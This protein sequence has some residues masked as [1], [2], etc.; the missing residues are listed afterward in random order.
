MQVIEAKQGC[1]YFICHLFRPGGL[2]FA[3]ELEHRFY[4]PDE[5]INEVFQIF[6]V[7]YGAGPHYAIEIPASKQAYQQAETLAEE[8][9]LKLVPG[10]PFNG[11]DEFPIR[12]AADK[13]F[14][15][16]TAVHDAMENF[17]EEITALKKKYFDSLHKKRDE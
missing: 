14:V 11:Q 12:C 10:K 1:M 17:E 9:N 16:E 3:T 2:T 13:C 8:M 7:T 15:L 5:A 6:N 4:P